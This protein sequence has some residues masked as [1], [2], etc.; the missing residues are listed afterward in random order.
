MWGRGR[1][2]GGQKLAAQVSGQC[3]AMRWDVGLKGISMTHHNRG[4][5]TTSSHAAPVSCQTPQDT[6]ALLHA[7]IVTVYFWVEPCLSGALTLDF[8][9]C[10]N[11]VTHAIIMQI[12]TQN[13]SASRSPTH[14][15]PGY[16]LLLVALFS[17]TSNYSSTLRGAWLS[18]HNRVDARLQ[19]WT[20]MIT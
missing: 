15:L 13:L 19:P 11:K 7:S 12:C 10:I 17:H 3:G 6:V 5:L 1:L 4:M 9:G 18:E 2:A 14:P 8:S 20:R 16:C